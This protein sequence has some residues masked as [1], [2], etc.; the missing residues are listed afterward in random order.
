M[1]HEILKHSYPHCWRHKTPVIFRATEQWFIKIDKNKLRYK[2]I[3]EIKKVSWIPK[4]GE[5][6]IKQMIK[7]R[8]DWCISRQRKWG[9]PMCLFIH[10]KTGNIHPENTFLMEKII[11]KST[12]KLQKSTKKVS[13]STKKYEKMYRKVQR[14]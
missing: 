4:W 3:E 9:V 8:P 2:T 14:E 12:K 6:R 13:K 5:S 1:H 11:K 10:K 7:K